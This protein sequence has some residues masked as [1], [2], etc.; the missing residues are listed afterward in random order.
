M[1]M[2]S[3]LGLGRVVCV[4]ADGKRGNKPE[5]WPGPKTRGVKVEH[6]MIAAE[7]AIAH[8]TRTVDELSE[9]VTRQAR[10]I[11]VLNAR[12]GLLMDREAERE[13]DSGSSIPLA[14]QRPPHW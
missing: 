4:L 13:A 8:L 3:P 5:R 7:E 2:G 1:A 11:A 12:V 6:R 14:D 9:V 10:E